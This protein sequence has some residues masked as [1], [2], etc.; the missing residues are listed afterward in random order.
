M[1]YDNNNYGQN[2]YPQGQQGQ[3]YNQGIYLC[4]YKCLHMYNMYI[5]KLWKYLNVHIYV[6][7][8]VGETKQKVCICIYDYIH[9]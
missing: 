8:Y 9:M 5:C 3:N 6:Y 2:N 4:I 1:V 7:L